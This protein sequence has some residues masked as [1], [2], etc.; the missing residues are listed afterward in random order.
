VHITGTAEPKVVQFC[1]RV[2]YINS[3][4]RVTYHQQQGRGYGHVTVLNFSCLSWC[5]ASRGFVSDSWATCFKHAKQTCSIDVRNFLLQWNSLSNTVVSAS[6][7]NSF[8]RKLLEVNLDRFF[9]S[10][11]DFI[12]VCILLLIFVVL[13]NVLYYTRVLVAC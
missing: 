8:K 2:G 11:N 9:T 10:M 1:T 12:A 4:N 13:C 5:S 7:I 6:S 3:N